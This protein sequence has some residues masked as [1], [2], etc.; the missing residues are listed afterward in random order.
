MVLDD[1]MLEQ[2]LGSLG[3]EEYYANQEAEKEEEEEENIDL[4]ELEKEFVTG[5]ESNED[6][7]FGKHEDD[8]FCV[9]VCSALKEG[10]VVSG[11]GDDKLY[12]YKWERNNVK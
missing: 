6:F 7:L 5:L 8:K 12:V 1:D 2:I 11:G 3:E 9:S 4:N 10:I